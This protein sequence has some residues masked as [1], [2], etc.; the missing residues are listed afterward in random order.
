[1]LKSNSIH[2]YLVSA[3]MAA[4]VG[5]SVAASAKGQEGAMRGELTSVVMHAKTSAKIA[6]S[7]GLSAL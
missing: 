3:L 7:G 5:L 2:R 1:M 4:T 6:G